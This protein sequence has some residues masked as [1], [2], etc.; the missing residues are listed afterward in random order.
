MV[1]SKLT[2]DSDDPKLFFARLRDSAFS[3]E[4]GGVV[5]SEVIHG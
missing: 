1:N 3:R 4:V 2:T 5:R